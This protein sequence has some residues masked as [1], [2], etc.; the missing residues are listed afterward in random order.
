MNVCKN[1]E[2]GRKNS[3]QKKIVIKMRGKTS[4]I[5]VHANKKALVVF[6]QAKE[7]NLVLQVRWHIIYIFYG[8]LFCF[9]QN[10]LPKKAT[11]RFW[12]AV[13]RMIRAPPP[14][15]PAISHDKNMHTRWSQAY[16]YIFVEERSRQL[17]H[18]A[19]WELTLTQLTLPLPN[20][21][22]TLWGATIKGENPLT[23]ATELL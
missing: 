4:H 11:T 14:P 9:V 10:L 19:S 7:K 3:K 16:N 12:S 8:R 22:V 1:R 23:T 18:N 5:K 2:L 20:N 6:D 21:L 17:F 13:C 15:P